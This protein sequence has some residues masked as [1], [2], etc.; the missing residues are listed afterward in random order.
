MNCI[1]RGVPVPIAVVVYGVVIAPDVVPGEGSVHFVFGLPS[2]ERFKMLNT[3]ARKLSANR[4]VTGNRFSI[5]MSAAQSPGKRTILR[6]ALPHTPLAGVVK[7][8]G[9]NHRS[10]V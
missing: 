2:C 5:E 7:A 6:P 10:G 9:F 8:N 1:C 3:S 4:S